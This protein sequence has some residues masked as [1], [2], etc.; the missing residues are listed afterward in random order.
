MSRPAALLLAM[1][2][3]TVALG[4]AAPAVAQPAEPREAAHAERV[5]ADV[6]A[7]LS[8]PEF[9]EDKRESVLQR[10]GDWLRERLVALLRRL[11]RLFRF[12]GIA[13]GPGRLLFWL[14]AA[15]L[16]VGIGYLI[17]WSVRSAAR[18]SGSRPGSRPEVSTAVDPQE[19]GSVGPEA[20]L[21]AAR[22]HAA[23]GDS[24]RAYRAAFNAVLMRLDRAGAIEFARSRTNGE[25]V[26]ALGRAPSLLALFRPLSLEF[27]ARW[28]GG[29]PIAGDDIGRCLQTYERIGASGP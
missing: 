1:L 5:R 21:E 20:W 10:V 29:A 16:L 27:D 26:R 4:A 18:R 24:R 9:R 13:A 22:R 3:A 23:A 7:I 14:L 15:A 19:A 17:A 6:R 25:Y 8:Q 28:Y 12:G 2:L 11:G